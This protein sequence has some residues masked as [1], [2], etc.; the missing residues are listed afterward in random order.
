[1]EEN[2]KLPKEV[3]DEIKRDVEVRAAHKPNTSYHR[4][5]KDGEIFGAT[6][7]ATKWFTCFE[8]NGRMAVIIADYI[9]KI[10]VLE[11]ENNKLKGEVD[12]LKGMIMRHAIAFANW[13]LPS[14]CIANEK[15]Y[16]LFLMKPEAVLDESAAGREEAVAFAEWALRE[17]WATSHDRKGWMKHSD[18]T[19]YVLT[20]TELNE[21]FKQQKEK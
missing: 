5:Y 4:G 14:G 9:D 18:D 12:G 15:D 3:V 19:P 16:E 8:E 21:L 10:K 7:Y 17:G 20:T 6:A 1:M 2:T 11:Y 13:L